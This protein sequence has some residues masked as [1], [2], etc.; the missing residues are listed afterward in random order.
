MSSPPTTEVPDAPDPLALALARKR[1]S[2]Y[3]T[4]AFAT[5][6]TA[7]MLISVA[8]IVMG[9]FGIGFDAFRMPGPSPLGGG[10]CADALRGLEA[11]VERALGAAA[12]AP[13][14]AEATKVYAASLS[15]E[16]DDETGVVAR[17]DRERGGPE[18]YGAVLRLRR[19]GE[20]VA[21][22]QVIEL[23]P[24]R[25][26]V[27]AYLAPLAASTASAP[28]TAPPPPEPGAS[29]RGTGVRPTP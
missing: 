22:R 14:E 4:G 25:Q 26:T 8:H 15:P 3:L 29:A 28:T 19:A 18:A 20:D 12:R 9:V 21:R 7:F 16:W 11:S 5:F 1:G 10:A 17:C 2:R 13:T 6:A 23:G 24:L 27:S